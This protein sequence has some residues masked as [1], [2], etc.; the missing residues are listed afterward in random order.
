MAAMAASPSSL[1]LNLPKE[2]VDP[3]H[4]FIDTAGTSFQTFL[5]SAAG[6]DIRCLPEDYS[7]DLIEPLSKVGVKFYGSVHVEAMPDDGSAEVAW[8]EGMSAD[9]RCAYV[10]G[11]VASCDLTRDDVEEE[12]LKIIKTSP[13]VRGIRWILD[14]VGK[15]Q[16]GKTATHVATLR[17]DGIDHL[18]TPEFERG[19]AMLEK[20]GLSFDLQCAPVQLVE[21]AAAL[22]A[23]YPNLKVCIDHLG[24]PRKVLGDDVLEDG[25]MNPNVVR[26]EKELEVWRKGMKA[27]AALPNVYVKLSMMGYAIPGWIRTKERQA[28]LKSVV[29]EIVEMFGPERCMAA[30]NWH[31]NAAVSDA[32]NMSDVGPDAVELLEMFAWFFEGYTEEERERLFAGTAKEFYGLE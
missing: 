28:A 6:G 21:S 24:K 22:F 16:G 2:V 13:K 11:Y 30:W 8:V 10:R 23:K 4:H 20:H 5:R 19:L 31:V 18:K 7:R 9:G 15:F 3:H 27:M 1:N 29:R 14:C 25:T 12:L 17:H 32:D 26:D